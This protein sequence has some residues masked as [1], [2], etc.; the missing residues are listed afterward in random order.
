MDDPTE[1]HN[2]TSIVQDNPDLKLY[3][4]DFDCTIS[5]MSK[6]ERL[7]HPD[8]KDRSS[9]VSAEVVE[10]LLWIHSLG[11]HLAIVSY[12]D[13]DVIIKTLRSAGITENIIP[14]RNIITLDNFIS[15]ALIPLSHD[16]GHLLVPKSRMLDK[17]ALRLRLSR[18]RVALVDDSKENIDEAYDTGYSVLQIAGRELCRSSSQ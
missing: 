16:E 8:L 5:T 12:A 6:A 7:R 2:I 1:T 17:L 15:P 10:V 3:A 13:R 14:A 9:Y 18:S 11:K 4:L